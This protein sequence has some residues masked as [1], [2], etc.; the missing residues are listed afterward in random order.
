MAAVTTSGMIRAK[1]VSK[2]EKNSWEEEKNIVSCCSPVGMVD[3][4]YSG[5]ARPSS[6]TGKGNETRKEKRR[7]NKNKKGKKTGH[8]NE[9]VPKVKKN[10]N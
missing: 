9:Q 7:K 6:V 2:V 5:N 3:R 4:Q 1:Y 8:F 10:K